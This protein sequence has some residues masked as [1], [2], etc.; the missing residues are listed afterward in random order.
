MEVVLELN[1]DIPMLAIN[2]EGVGEFSM[3]DQVEHGLKE[4]ILQEGVM[5]GS[6]MVQHEHLNKMKSCALDGESPVK[7]ATL[8]RETRSSTRA[9]CKPVRLA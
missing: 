6:E 7:K 5:S 4:P 3:E 2:D 9:P 8:K 1:V